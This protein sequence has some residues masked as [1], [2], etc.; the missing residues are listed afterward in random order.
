MVKALRGYSEALPDAKVR[1]ARW[2]RPL[3]ASAVCDGGARSSPRFRRWTRSAWV[4]KS[5]SRSARPDLTGELPR[6]S[7]LLACV[8]DTRI[9]GERISRSAEPWRRASRT[10]KFWAP[11]IRLVSA[12]SAALVR[13]PSAALRS[14][15]PVYGLSRSA[16][17][18]AAC[19]H[20]QHR[21]HER[22]RCD[23]RRRG[24]VPGAGPSHARL[25][26]E[27]AGSKAA[28]LRC[29]LVSGEHGCVV[30]VLDNWVALTLLAQC[31]KT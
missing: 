16:G 31:T 2:R 15:P 8:A 17:E 13:A 14:P 1:R 5:T 25:S 22:N 18:S 27:H 26:E 9:L 20:D 11:I 10:W 29:R 30:C 28:N 19:T 21:F 23:A 3:V 6:A 4:V 12:P 7:A 24:V